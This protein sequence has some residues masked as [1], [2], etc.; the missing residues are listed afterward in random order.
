MAEDYPYQTELAEEQYYITK[1]ENQSKSTHA[2]EA[3]PGKDVTQ[4][5]AESMIVLEELADEE[6]DGYLEENPRLVPL[7]EVDVEE[8]VSPYIV[9]TE[10]AGEEPNKNAIRE[11]RQ[12]QETWEREMV[13]SHRVKAS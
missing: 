5:Y 2:T 1:G 3:G 7:F 4:L 12:A 11:L 13:V 6:V 10:D 8:A 9:Q